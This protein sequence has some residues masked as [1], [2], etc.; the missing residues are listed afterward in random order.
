[1]D[2]IISFKQLRVWQCSINIV[3]NIYMISQGF[4]QEEL[5]GLTAQMRRS[6]ISIPSNIAEGFKRYHPKEF[7]QFLH[8]ALGSAAE[9][10]TQIIISK[11]L[12]FIKSDT[13]ESVVEEI[14]Y[15]SR[16]ITALKNKLNSRQVKIVERCTKY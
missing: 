6:A 8:V 9:L 1:M 13:F 14:N 2:K 15:I 7:R 11:E 12:N 5:Y 4:P 3:K 10:E 16:M